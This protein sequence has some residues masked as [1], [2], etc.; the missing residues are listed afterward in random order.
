MQKAASKT[1]MEKT[2]EALGDKF[3]DEITSVSKKL[4]LLR[5]HK[6]MKLKMNQKYQKKDTYH[7]KKDNK[8][9]MN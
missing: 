3:A 9:L 7:Q 6:V 4:F 1:A 5:A 2:A 8:L